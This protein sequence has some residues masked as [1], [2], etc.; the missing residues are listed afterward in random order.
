MSKY[1]FIAS[2]TDDEISFAGMMYKL[3]QEKHDVNFLVL[4][5]CYDDNLKGECLSA[6][7]KLGVVPVFQNYEVRMFRKKAN[8]IA[9]LFSFTQEMDF[10]VTHSPI[11]KHPDHR[12]V[13]KEALRVF[14]CS[15]LTFLQPW[16]G[17]ED[18]NYFVEL[19]EQQL[20]KKIEAL[21]CY[22]SQAHRHYMDPDFIRSWA[23]YTGGKIGKKYAEGFRVERLIV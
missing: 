17:N 4:S 19:S 22:K 7:K 13:G 9:N 15:L 21:A 12:T 2:H 8:S 3:V 16:N 6:S 11:C 23:R 5:Y 18:S 1:L 10:V 14:K 20:E